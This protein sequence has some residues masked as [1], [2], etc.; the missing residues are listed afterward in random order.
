MPGKPRDT[1]QTLNITP[2]ANGLRVDRA[3]YEAVRKAVLRAVPGSRSGITFADLPGA[4]KRH[5][6]G[7]RI[8]GGGAIMW[9]STVVKLDLEARGL[10]ERIEGS[11][12]QRLRRAR[13]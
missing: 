3:K 5:L 8:P 12:P 6:P 10:I 11:R 1:I 2:G 13:S 9:Y 7:G 4:V